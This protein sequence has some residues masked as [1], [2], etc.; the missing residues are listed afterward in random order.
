MNSEPPFDPEQPYEPE[1]PAEL[2][3]HHA[4]SQKR[5]LAFWAKILASKFLFVSILVHVLFGAGATLYVVQRY[6]NDRKRTFQGGPPS[7]NPSSRALEHKVSLAKKKNTQSAP[8]QAK[9]ITSTAISKIALP[10]MPAMANVTTVT[11]NRM[12]GLGGQG[13]GSGAGGGGMGTGGGGF[14]LPNVMGDRCTAASRAQAMRANGGDPKAEE[15]IKKGLQWLKG[16]QN[17]DGS[18]GEQ[19]PV[20][21]TGLALLAYLGHCERPTSTEYGPT[22]K[23][24]IEYLLGVGNAQDGKLSKAG[25]TP[26][27]Y[28]HGI[29]TY[30]LGEAYILTKDPKIA[31]VFSKACRIIVYG[32]GPDG[33][34]MYNYDKSASDTSVSGWQV[35]ALKTAVLSGLSIPEADAALKKSV[36]N[37]MRCRGANGGFGYRG[38]EDKQSL[39]GVGVVMLQIAIHERGQVVRKALDLYIDHKNA[40]VYN[41]DAGDANLYSWYYGA[42][43]CF[44]YGGSPWGKWNRIVMPQ[45][46]AHQTA[47]GNWS[48]FGGAGGAG[49]DHTGKGTTSDAEVYRTSL[50]SLMLEVYYRY[51]AS[52]R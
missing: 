27:V 39:T 31:E 4:P 34:W 25:G 49:F 17:A 43:A 45:I 36:G 9:R 8:A 30:A 18:F 33:G 29:A 7:V 21:M 5:R 28:E 50:C 52:N 1:Q 26:W 35:Q 12:S 13:F 15:A 42:Q 46:I 10:E 2:P 51:L 32:Q 24:A 22:V 16:H 19:Y 23:K 6:Q 40:P 44:Q 11:P 48:P 14:G 37:V 47:D 41:Y 38:P 3:P 20:A